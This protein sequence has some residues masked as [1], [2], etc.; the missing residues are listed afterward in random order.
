MINR[1][2][3]F[4]DRPGDRPPEDDY[5]VVASPWD[6]FYVARDEAERILRELRSPWSPRWVRFRDV[7]GSSVCLRSRLILYVREC[8]AEQRAAARRFWRAREE[9]EKADRYPWEDED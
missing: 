1:L 5:Y 3:L 8:T 4:F 7:H 9:E 6:H 2:T